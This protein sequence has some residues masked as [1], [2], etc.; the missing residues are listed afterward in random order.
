MKNLSVSSKLWL[1]V[2]IFA[3]GFLAFGAL[4]YYTLS[5]VKVNGPLYRNIV[6]GKDLIADVL[7]PPEYII[8]SYLLVLQMQDEADP[9]ALDDLAR[10]VRSLQQEYDT[11]HAFWVKDL[12]DDT[13]KET[14]V[15][16][17]YRP[18]V[19]FFRAVDS[20]F[21][22]VLRKGDR[23]KA[24]Q[25]A[26]EVLKEKYEAHRAAID[27]VVQMATERNRND[28]RK[29]A[30]FI[31][32]QTFVLVSLGFAIVAVAMLVSWACARF[33]TVPLSRAV[34]VADRLAEGE[35]ELRI[36]TS[37]ADEVGRLLASMDKM[38]ASQK[39]MASAAVAISEGDL[40][41]HVSP[42]SERDA[43]G[44]ALARM[45]GRLTGTIAGVRSAAM[46]LSSAAAQVSSSSQT[47]SQGTSE[48]AA[49]VEETT[50][51]L[52][53]MSASIT[54]NSENS[55]Q[56][57]QMAVKGA[58]DA[59]EGGRSVKETVEAM[60]SIAEKISIV[61]EI[62]YQTNL[63]ALNAAI[64]AARAGEHGKGF[65][66]VAS[67][68]RKLAERSQSAAKDIGALAS[69]SVKVAERSGRLLTELVPAIRKTTE[70]V[71]EV[72]AASAEQSSGVAQINRAMSQ[73][74]QVTQ[75]NASAAE[76]LSATAQELA[77]QADGLQQSIAFF[78]LDG[79]D[80]PAPRPA[81]S[82]VAASSG[83]VH[84]GEGARPFRPS[85]VKPNGGG[86]SKGVAAPAS[87]ADADF[88]PF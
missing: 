64:E 36:E 26:R 38:V 76:E 88:R 4:S 37:S 81:P 45:V 5:T 40:T 78:R 55:R 10:R 65:A 59:E 16:T 58:Q 49:S 6:Q 70:L 18:A 8:E 20:E 77:R 28:E 15:E 9:K 66:V 32:K 71:Q 21:V 56:T 53:Q 62:A 54:Q 30:E 24:R 46:S 80:A 68:V 75:R 85:G 82:T 43:L 52:E 50:S 11:R 63:L 1:L 14:M 12:P 41:A 72:T 60:A 23:E 69:S 39:Q 42:R 48:Q 51:S 79:H 57:E 3:S 87:A 19:E 2:G 17:S 61:E 29:A 74:D 86:S 34:E 22:P 83:A 35:V 47:L 73:V 44:N 27:R 31:A 84:G 25:V 13:L 7:P 33:I 67:E